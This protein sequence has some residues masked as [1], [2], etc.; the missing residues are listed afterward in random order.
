MTNVDVSYRLKEFSGK[1]E[2]LAKEVGELKKGIGI[3]EL[4]DNYDMVNNWK[5]SLRTLA[6]WRAEGLIDYVKVGSMIWYPK[7]AREI[8]LK[9]NTVKSKNEEDYAGEEN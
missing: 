5:V 1:M 2:N 6:T 4:W 7:E 9:A 8:F 3:N